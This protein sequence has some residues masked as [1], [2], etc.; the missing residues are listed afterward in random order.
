MKNGTLTTGTAIYYTGDR[1]NHDGF[2]TVI[3]IIPPN[4]W[5]GEQAVIAMDDGRQFTHSVLNTG[6]VYDGHCGTRFVTA[7][8]YAAWRKAEMERFA[9]LYGKR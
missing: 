9:E 1:A 8:S 5:G 4:P 7:A 2:G 6:D 3:R